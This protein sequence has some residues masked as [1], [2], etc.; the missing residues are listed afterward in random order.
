MVRV[1]VPVIIAAVL[2]SMLTDFYVRYRGS[3][4]TT[5]YHANAFDVALRRLTDLGEGLALR[6]LPEDYTNFWDQDDNEMARRYAVVR[7]L[8]LTFNASIWAVVASVGALSFVRVRRQRGVMRAIGYICIS[9]AGLFLLCAAG[10][11][12][13]YRDGVGSMSGTSGALAWSRF[14]EAFRFALLIGAAILLFGLWCV[15]R[16]RRVTHEPPTI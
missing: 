2:L 16:R 8:K 9:T 4:Y 15:S 5:D 7:T 12:W 11:C 3:L 6:I 13:F 10:N 1:L 14:W